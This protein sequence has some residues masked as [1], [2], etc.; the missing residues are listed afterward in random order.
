M[1]LLANLKN[2]LVLL[3]VALGVLSYAVLTQVV[4]TWFIRRFGD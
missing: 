4:K 3:L 2:P 1:R